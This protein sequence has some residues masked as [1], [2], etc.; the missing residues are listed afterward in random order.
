[1]AL[2]HKI[3]GDKRMRCSGIKENVC[4]YGIYKKRT[5]YHV[6]RFLSLFRT[7]MVELSFC[8][9]HGKLGSRVL[10]VVPIARA[11]SWGIGALNTILLL[12]AGIG[13]M[14]FQSTLKAG[15]STEVD[16]VRVGYFASKFWIA[17]RTSGVVGAWSRCISRCPLRLMRGSWRWVCTRLLMLTAAIA[18][19][20]QAAL[21]TF[22]NI[23]VLAFHK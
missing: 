17:T 5:Q 16:V 1:M 12:G 8:R 6:R 20:H 14:H 15:N 21:L 4:R 11:R 2:F 13:I 18:L 9:G 22:Y 19:I 23:I 3:F 10:V 7:H